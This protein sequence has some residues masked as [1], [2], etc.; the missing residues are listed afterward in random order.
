MN[1]SVALTPVAFRDYNDRSLGDEGG[2]LRQSLDDVA[3]TPTTRDRG[4]EIV[5]RV[6]DA[7]EHA[8]ENDGTLVDADV[9]SRTLHFLDLLPREVPLPTVVVESEHEIG[10]D[11]DEGKRN[12]VSITL[13]ETPMMGFSALFG[14]EP[15]YGRL[16]LVEGLPD[17]LRFLLVRLF[18]K[19]RRA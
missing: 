13:D 5:K 15:L 10:L 1:V 16:N 2:L 4:D 9:F 18:P 6:A 14:R 12:I 11:W 8:R 19:K 17:T 3:S 7:L